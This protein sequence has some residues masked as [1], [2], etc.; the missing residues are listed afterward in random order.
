MYCGGLY[1]DQ[2]NQRAEGV[3]L[4]YNSHLDHNSIHIS[5]YFPSEDVCSSSNPKRVHFPPSPLVTY[6]YWQME[7]ILG[8]M[9]SIISNVLEHPD[10]FNEPEQVREREKKTLHL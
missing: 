10:I 1:S 3:Q 6:R 9:G 7:G 2:D 5:V 4:G 8:M